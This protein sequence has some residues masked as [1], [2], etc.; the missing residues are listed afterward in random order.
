MRLELRQ[1]KGNGAGTGAQ[2]WVLERGRRTLGRSIDCDWQ[3]PDAGRTVSKLHCTILRDRDGYLL[4]DESANGT[5]VDGVLVLEGE[6]ARLRH[7][8]RLELGGH[9]FAVSVIGEADRDIVDP[10]AGLAVSPENLTITAILADIA[11]GG[12]IATGVMGGRLSDDWP[13][14]QPNAPVAKGRKREAPPSSRHVEIGWD[15]PP[16]PKAIKPVLP[17]DW[18]EDFDYGNRLEH[19]RATFVSVPMARGRSKDNAETA[20]A[21][22]DAIEAAAP[23]ERDEDPADFLPAMAAPF[24]WPPRCD[25]LLAQCEEALERAFVPFEIDPAALTPAPDVFGLDREEALLRRLETL[26]AR[27]QALADALGTLVREVGPQLEPRII[28]ASIDARAISLPWRRN[29][30]YWQAYRRQF[31]ADGRDLSVRDLFRRAMLRSLEPARN[32]P[33]GGEPAPTAHS[34]TS[35]DDEVA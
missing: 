34:T 26:L 5:R 15:G 35:K 2:P 3:V 22:D 33:V 10:E 4:R 6:T 30:A 32:E 9:A 24:S 7:Q 20:P 19:G 25:T 11:P 16:D 27:Q 1:V 28:E 17:D 18:N 23:T 21:N 8:S 13:L 14:P 29:G 31:E 12:Q